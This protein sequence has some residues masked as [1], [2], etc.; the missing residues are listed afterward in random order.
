M[1]LAE[2]SGATVGGAAPVQP[3][4]SVETQPSAGSQQT[5]SPIQE[6]AEEGDSSTEDGS[7]SD[8]DSDSS[9][10]SGDESESE[11][12]SSAGPVAPLEDSPDLPSRE[13]LS[14]IQGTGAASG[15]GSQK[16]GAVSSSKENQTKMKST[17]ISSEKLEEQRSQNKQPIRAL[18]SLLRFPLPEI[19]FRWY[20][21]KNN[22][23]FR[24]TLE[25][26]GIKGDE[27]YIDGLVRVLTITADVL[28]ETRLRAFDT[29]QYYEHLTQKYNSYFQNTPDTEKPSIYKFDSYLFCWALKIWPRALDIIHE[30]SRR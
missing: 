3:E 25:D 2:Q 19:F 1:S 30:R 9:S 6:E 15:Q 10:E 11:L 4:S 12:R 23:I 22:N 5:S 8:S 27:E 24:I 29:K 28:R 21:E 13:N 18:K 16:P 7:G 17:P 14:V 20:R 26:L